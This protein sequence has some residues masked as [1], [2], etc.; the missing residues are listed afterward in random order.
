MSEIR[1]INFQEI[2]NQ[3]SS[4]EAI[5][6][7]IGVTA[8]YISQLV[9]GNRDMGEKSARK[10]E[11]KLNLP[12]NCLDIDRNIDYIEGE[13]V[14]RY[15]EINDAK[16]NT[17]PGPAIRGRV[18]LINYV[19]AGQWREI[20][21]S[22]DP[23]DWLD[24]TSNVSSQAFAL[25]VIGDSMTN[26]FGAPSIPEG[27]IVIVDPAIEAK[28][29]SFVIAKL[30]NTNEAILKQLIIDGPNHYLKSLNPDYKPIFI[31]ENCHICGVVKKV[32]FEP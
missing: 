17:E 25:R 20:M 23:I 7:A 32:E 12:L 26:P 19:Q 16:I 27:F 4:Q 22:I 31:N 8:G 3:Y 13:A 9:T 14:R 18:P 11:K 24:T 30:E 28:S 21:D 1:R 5:A 6:D 15:L 10:I 29:G 2:V